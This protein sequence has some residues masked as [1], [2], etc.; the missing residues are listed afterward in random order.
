MGLDMYVFGHNANEANQDYVGEGL[1]YWR[2]HP[3]LHGYIV[4]TFADGVDECQRIPLTVEQIDQT[5]AAVRANALPHT[6]GFF[7]GVSC[8]ADNN[9]T[10]EKL[11]AVKAWLLEHPGC[12]VYYQASW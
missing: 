6:D 9:N 8:C 2:K 10:T 5:I 11:Q 7:F 4:K 12:I 3:N 1:A